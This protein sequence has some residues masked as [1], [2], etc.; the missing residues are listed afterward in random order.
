MNLRNQLSWKIEWKKGMLL[1]V[2]P[3]TPLMYFY[4]IHWIGISICFHQRQSQQFWFGGTKVKVSHSES[5]FK[6]NSKY[7]IYDFVHWFD[8]CNFY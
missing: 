7:Y 5:Q 1:D 8:Q 4:Y 2:K 3:P 6:K